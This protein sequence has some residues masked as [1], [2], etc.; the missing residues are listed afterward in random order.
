MPS[1]RSPE[2][3]PD[4]PRF[5]ISCGLRESARKLRGTV[6]NSI[7]AMKKEHSDGSRTVSAQVGN[8]SGA[9]GI[10]DIRRPAMDRRRRLRNS[11]LLERDSEAC[12]RE[13]RGIL[14]DAGRAALAADFECM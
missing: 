14:D 9:A 3:S 13:L 10:E 4:S 2:E 1:A 8:A 5:G 7:L 6:L 11:D 12:E